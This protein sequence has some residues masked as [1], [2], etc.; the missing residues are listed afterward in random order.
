[1][2][3]DSKIQDVICLPSCN[4]LP[5]AFEITVIQV[6]WLCSHFFS[7]LKVFMPRDLAI[8]LSPVI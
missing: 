3:E 6:P 1:M 5:Q 4:R 8:A 7:L 2:L